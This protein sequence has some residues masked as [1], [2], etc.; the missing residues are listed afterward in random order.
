MKDWVKET[1]VC[2]I[3]GNWENYCETGKCPICEYDKTKKKKAKRYWV[4]GH[5]PGVMSRKMCREGIET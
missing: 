4:H 3:H 1:G 2:E 5:L